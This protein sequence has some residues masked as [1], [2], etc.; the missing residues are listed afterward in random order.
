VTC[1]LCD[2]RPVPESYGSERRCAF[3]ANGVFTCDN[4]NCE[5]I[6]ELRRLAPI[7]TRHCDSTLAVIPALTP[8]DLD[9]CHVVLN[10]Y[11]E[12]GSVSGA[13]VILDDS[14][15]APLTLEIAE[16]ILRKSGKG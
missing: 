13:R 3:H 12:R 5:T 16:A 14:E 1:H 9:E 6:N 15:D 11:K 10:W 2:T 7:V 8:V 4:W